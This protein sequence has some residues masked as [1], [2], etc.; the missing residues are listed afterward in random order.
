MPPVV[1]YV[2]WSC[3]PAVVFGVLVNAGPIGR[4]IRRAFEAARPPDPVPMSVPIER[5]AADL[6]RLAALVHEYDAPGAGVSMAKRIAANRAYGDRLADAC[7]A[8]EIPHRLGVTSGWERALELARVES[9]LLEAGLSFAPP[10]V[11]R[12]R[13]S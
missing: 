11:E 10:T 12:R 13:A 1:A 9:A 3:L 2:A 5:L 8:L 4:T 7:A 6:R